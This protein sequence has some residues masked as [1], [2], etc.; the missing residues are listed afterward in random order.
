MMQAHVPKLR[1]M[2]CAGGMAREQRTDAAWPAGAGAGPGEGD[3]S[4]GGDRAGGSGMRA[5]GHDG[6]SRRRPGHLTPTASVAA[7]ISFTYHLPLCS[8]RTDAR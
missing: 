2:R 1:P 5:G 3:G 8:S 7:L 4:P 6:V